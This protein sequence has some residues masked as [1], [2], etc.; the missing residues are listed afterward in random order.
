MLEEV[1][2]EMTKQSDNTIL[3]IFERFDFDEDYIVNHIY[4]FGVE[5][6]PI[7]NG[8]IKRF[9]RNGIS[10]FSVK[11]ETIIDDRHVVHHSITRIF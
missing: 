10:L 3:S 8:T 4:E 7:P 2:S 9:Y 11:S 5:E 6:T 1:I